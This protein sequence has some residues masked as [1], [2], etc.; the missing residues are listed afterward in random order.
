MINLKTKEIYRFNALLLY[1]LSYS[2]YIFFGIFYFFLNGIFFYVRV[3]SSLL[4]YVYIYIYYYTVHTFLKN[5]M[6]V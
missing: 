3:S 1:L 6:F 5:C 2:L 4:L